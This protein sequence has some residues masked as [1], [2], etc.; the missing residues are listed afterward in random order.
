MSSCWHV[1]LHNAYQFGWKLEEGFFRIFNR[2]GQGFGDSPTGSKSGWGHDG[3]R[4]LFTVSRGGTPT[5]SVT[6]S[7]NGS[8]T[9][10]TEGALAGTLTGSMTGLGHRERES[11]TVEKLISSGSVL[12]CSCWSL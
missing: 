3:T 2:L 9:T 1:V 6:G 11:F 8:A 5:G 7:G 4:S 12:I 10:V